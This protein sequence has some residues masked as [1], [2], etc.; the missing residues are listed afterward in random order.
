[1]ML[2]RGQGSL[3]SVAARTRRSPDRDGD[4]GGLKR[5]ERA[6]DHRAASR[7][8]WSACGRP[9]QTDER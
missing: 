4:D 5:A 2:D 1:M 8:G 3:M 7:R 6:D 9:G